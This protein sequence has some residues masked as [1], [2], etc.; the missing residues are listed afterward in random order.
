MH[1]ARSNSLNAG[2]SAAAVK[3]EGG[4][5]SPAAGGKLMSAV[6][7]FAPNELQNFYFSEKENGGSGSGANYS[8][9]IPPQPPMMPQL[10]NIPQFIQQ[11]TIMTDNN[12]GCGGGSSSQQNL[13]YHNSNNFPFVNSASAAVT[14]VDSQFHADTNSQ[15]QLLYDNNLSLIHI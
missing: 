1:L 15:Q 12:N 9:I 8:S 6:G 10:A 4:G 13:Q 7:R 11:P 5:P 14:G 3:R 2:G